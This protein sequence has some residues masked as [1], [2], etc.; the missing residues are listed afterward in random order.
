MT[1]HRLYIP[2]R[3]AP[4][5]RSVATNPKCRTSPVLIV[6]CFLWWLSANNGGHLSAVSLHKC[7]KK[8]SRANHSAT[9]SPPC[10]RAAGVTPWSARLPRRV[11]LCCCG[12][13]SPGPLSD[14]TE[15]NWALATLL[16]LSVVRLGSP[17]SNIFCVSVSRHLCPRKRDSPLLRASSYL[18]RCKRRPG[19]ERCSSKSSASTKCKTSLACL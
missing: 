14:W 18:C 5:W 13:C 10:G 15:Q 12:V 11:R 4:F 3:R 2:L 9:F 19:S 17:S 6:C 8:K 1:S 7:L 16:D